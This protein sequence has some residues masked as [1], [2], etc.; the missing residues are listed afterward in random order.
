MRVFDAFDFDKAEVVEEAPIPVEDPKE[1]VVEETPVVEETSGI[2]DAFEFG[3]NA[4]DMTVVEVT[5]VMDAKA[6]EIDL[7][8]LLPPSQ[9]P[10]TFKGERYTLVYEGVCSAC[11]HCGMPLTDAVSI[12][13][14]L[15][16]ICSRKGYEAEDIKVSDD[17]EALM[18]LAEYPELVDWLSAKY[19]P[20][21]NRGLVN[22]LVRV[23]SLNRRSPVHSACTDAVEALGYKRL[24]SALRESLA[25]I[26]LTDSKENPDHYSMWIKKSEFSWAFYNEL[27]KLDGVALRKYPTKHTIVPKKHRVAMARLFVEYYA[28][29]CV[30]TANGAH[31]ISQQ[32][33]TVK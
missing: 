27:R 16:P 10:Y 24:A 20:Q 29:L 25:V 22:G 13:R 18:A 15:G 7:S 11:A 8:A 33:F 23:A 2:D 21:G 3:H 17:S 5:P 9:K 19:K 6:P 31:R 30:K 26:E 28:G 12:Q 1:E 14:G 4:G 32:W